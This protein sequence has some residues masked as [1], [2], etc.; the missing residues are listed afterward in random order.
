MLYSHVPFSFVIPAQA[1]IHRPVGVGGAASAIA[2]LMD[3]RLRGNDG[4]LSGAGL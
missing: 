3:S 1:G 4:L 2:V